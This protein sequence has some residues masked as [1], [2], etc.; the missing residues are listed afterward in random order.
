MLGRWEMREVA[1]YLTLT[2][3]RAL[4]I[5]CSKPPQLRELGSSLISIGGHEVLVRVVGFTIPRS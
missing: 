4:L 2:E 1:Q 3:G 5:W